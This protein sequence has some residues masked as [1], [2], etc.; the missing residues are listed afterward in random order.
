WIVRLFL[1]RLNRC[2]F[3]CATALIVDSYV[4]QA[5]VFN[6]VPRYAADDRSVARVS[7]ID[8]YV[9]YQDAPQFAHRNSGRP[10]H[11]TAEPEKDWRVLNVAHGDV[12]Y[13]HVFKQ[14]AVNSL[15]RQAATVI[16]DYV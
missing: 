5:H 15:K 10:A 16:E 14:R 12:C 6:I 11:T 3:T 1:R 9:A 4:A 7:V 13:R 8:D 2:L